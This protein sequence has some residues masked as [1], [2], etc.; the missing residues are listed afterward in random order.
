[1]S[2]IPLSGTLGTTHPSDTYAIY[3]SNLTE[4]GL[5][6]VPDIAARGEDKCLF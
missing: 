5:H 6:S 1:M 3:D 2:K 4:G